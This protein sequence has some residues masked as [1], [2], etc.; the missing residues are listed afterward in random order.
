MFELIGQGKK[1]RDRRNKARNTKAGTVMRT[2]M[3][4]KHG[5]RKRGVWRIKEEYGDGIGFRMSRMMEPIIA[6]FERG[7]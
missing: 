2:A 3:N 4:T 5:D 1:K 6:R 7:R